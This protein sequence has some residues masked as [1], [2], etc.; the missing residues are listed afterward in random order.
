MIISRSSEV[1]SPRDLWETLKQIKHRS[2]QPKFCPICKGHNLS[3]TTLTGILPT[4]YRCTDCGYEDVLF[5]EV[6]PEMD[7]ECR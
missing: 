6:N 2:P 5:L 4:R 7:E 3:P 1:P